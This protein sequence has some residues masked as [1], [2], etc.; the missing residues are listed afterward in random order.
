VG[1]ELTYGRQCYKFIVVAHELTFGGRQRYK[2]IV[3]GHE[4]T[5]GRQCY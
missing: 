2:F 3:V 4:L 5:Y 1:H